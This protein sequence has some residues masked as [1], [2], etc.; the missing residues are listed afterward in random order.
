MERGSD[1]SNR[2]GVKVGWEGLKKRKGERLQER[3]EVTGK[4]G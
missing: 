2:K 1:G 4:R 3:R